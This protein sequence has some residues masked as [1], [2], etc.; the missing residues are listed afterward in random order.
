VLALSPHELENY[1][2]ILGPMIVGVALLSLPIFFN[3]GE[4]HPLR[5]PWSIAIVGITC[6]IIGVLWI[7]G[8]A[9]PWSPDFTAQALKPEIVQ[10]YTTKPQPPNVV[11]G[12]ELFYVRGCLYC[13]AIE[14]YGGH[15]GPDLSII[16]DQLNRMELKIR[17]F[18]RYRKGRILWIEYQ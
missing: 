6:L 4:R 8:N 9:S 13:H 17:I 3:R 12:A 2:I 16:G 11:E 15:R 1:I 7:L 14:G 5:R 10:G 18:N